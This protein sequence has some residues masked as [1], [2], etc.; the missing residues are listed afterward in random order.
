MR[1][2][3]NLFIINPHVEASALEALMVKVKKELKDAGA[4]LLKVEELGKKR[5]AYQIKHQKYGNYVLFIFE[6]ET[7]DS[8]RKFEDWLNINDDVLGN[9]TVKLECV[10]DLTAKSVI[11]DDLK[12]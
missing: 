9:M 10:P 11:Q 2:Y 3:E 1:Y 7:K 12:D 4:V 8:V 5:L 6:S